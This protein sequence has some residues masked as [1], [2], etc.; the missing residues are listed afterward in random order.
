M[1]KKFH[2]RIKHYISSRYIIQYSYSY[3][4]KFWHTCEDIR[5]YDYSPILLKFNDAIEFASKIKTI[6]DVEKF[7]KTKSVTLPRIKNIL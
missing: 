2:V 4:F 5:T 6:S 7:S 1:N 3:L